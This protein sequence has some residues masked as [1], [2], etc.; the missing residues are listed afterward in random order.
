MVSTFLFCRI[1]Y[2]QIFFKVISWLRI[3]LGWPCLCEDV[4]FIYYCKRTNKLAFRN[5]S[6]SYMCF[7]YSKPEHSWKLKI[8]HKVIF[9]KIKLES[10]CFD[11]RQTLHVMRNIQ[12]SGPYLSISQIHWA[13]EPSPPLFTDA[14]PPWLKGVSFS[15]QGPFLSLSVKDL[16]WCYTNFKSN[17]FLSQEFCFFFLKKRIHR[18]TQLISQ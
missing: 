12:T 5:M 10:D 8:T 2:L 3:Q 6:W 17:C 4:G 18:V 16:R 9:N 14:S 13:L 15:G 1:W 7:V 11:V